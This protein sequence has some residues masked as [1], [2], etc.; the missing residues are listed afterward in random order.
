[1]KG[2]IGMG[3]FTQSWSGELFGSPLIQTGEYQRQKAACIKAEQ[4]EKFPHVNLLA[5][6]LLARVNLKQTAS[7]HPALVN[8][9]S[10]HV[11][12]PRGQRE[13]PKLT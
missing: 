7:L 9:C 12:P 5:P 1:M 6:C 3:E 2:K 10:H 8:T 11:K 4:R 13:R